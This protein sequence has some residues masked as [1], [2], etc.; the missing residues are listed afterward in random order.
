MVNF[1]DALKSISAAEESTSAGIETFLFKLHKWTGLLLFAL[2][3]FLGLN[4]F[5][6]E[7]MHCMGDQVDNDWATDY[8]F[9]VQTIFSLPNSA[10]QTKFGSMKGNPPLQVNPVQNLPGSNNGYEENSKPIYHA[11]YIWIPLV[12]CFQGALFQLPHWLWEAY[13]NNLITN[14]TFFGD[15]KKD[16]VLRSGVPRRRLHLEESVQKKI[17]S[18]A[19]YVKDSME[20]PSRYIFNVYNRYALMYITSTFLNLVNVIAQIVFIDYFLVGTFYSYGINVLKMIWQGYDWRND[21]LTTVFPRVTK[22]FI[23]TFGLSGGIE[24]HDVLCINPLNILNEKMYVFLWFWLLILAMFSVIN[25]IIILAL[26]ISPSKMLNYGALLSK[27]TILF[28]EHVT[29]KAK[30]KFGDKFFLYLLSKN[31]EAQL[32]KEFLDYMASE[33]GHVQNVLNEDEE[34]ISKDMQEEGI[35]QSQQPSDKNSAM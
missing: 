24:Y 1:L 33:V 11:Y 5:I 6:G 28:C 21:P 3:I 7:P 30:Y 17:E 26:T 29:E 27:N 34:P 13:E 22:C 19:R 4:E 20:M 16:F 9:W 31:M 8:C 2:S 12:L 35:D 25:I 10:G 14:L 23:P 32:F 18:I 15:P